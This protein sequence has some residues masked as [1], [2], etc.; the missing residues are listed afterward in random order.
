MHERHENF[1]DL[2]AM[3]TN[4]MDQPTFASKIDAFWNLYDE[5]QPVS[6]PHEAEQSGGFISEKG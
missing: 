4:P 2:V 5:C 1:L 6:Y 3:I